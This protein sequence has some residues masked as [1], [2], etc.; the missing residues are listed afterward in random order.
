MRSDRRIGILNRMIYI[1]GAFQQ[2]ITFVDEGFAGTKPV[3]FDQIV[4]DQIIQRIKTCGGEGI[5][6]CAVGVDILEP[7]VVI[8][9]ENDAAWVVF[10]SITEII[11]EEESFRKIPLTVAMHIFG[12]DY[13]DTA[14]PIVGNLFRKIIQLEKLIT[15]ENPS[16]I[17]DIGSRI[18]MRPDRKQKQSEQEQEYHAD[19]LKTFQNHKKPPPMK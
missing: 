17:N 13:I 6:G 9:C 1:P 18:G 14:F 15:C 19:T 3:V 5:T 10:Q 11:V 2:F 16:L 4:I 12:D 8:D 7:I